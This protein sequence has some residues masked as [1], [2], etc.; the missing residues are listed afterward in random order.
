MENQGKLQ[1]EKIE[2]NENNI[3]RINKILIN[4][5]SWKEIKLVKDQNGKIYLIC[6]RGKPLQPRAAH[7]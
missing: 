6:Q 1:T 4:K 2:I 5:K 3:S 7:F